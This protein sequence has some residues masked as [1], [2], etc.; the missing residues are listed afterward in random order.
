MRRSLGEA[1]LDRSDLGLHAAEVHQ[2][3]VACAGPLLRDVRLRRR[4]D[5]GRGACG[6]ERRRHRLGSVGSATHERRREDERDGKDDEILH[7]CTS[8]CGVW[9]V[10]AP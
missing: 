3:L 5:G 2:V 7:G 4:H 9:N 1:L 8:R 6:D 10:S